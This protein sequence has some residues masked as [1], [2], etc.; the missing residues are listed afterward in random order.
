M[1]EQEEAADEYT[2]DR[3]AELARFL[4]ARTDPLLLIRPEAPDTDRA[5][6]A[7][8]DTVRVLLGQARAFR[9]WGN[10]PALVGTWDA[11]TTIAR[12]WRHHP[13]FLTIGEWE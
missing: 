6:Q 11:L 1:D 10:E 8:N 5:V 9:E 3:F 12:Q 7:L 13:D 4:F 2:E